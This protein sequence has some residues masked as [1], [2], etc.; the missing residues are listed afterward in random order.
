VGCGLGGYKKEGGGV[1][2]APIYNLMCCKSLILLGLL[3][4]VC[5]NGGLFVHIIMYMQAMVPNAVRGGCPGG[6]GR[7]A[8]LAYVPQFATIYT[9]R[10]DWPGP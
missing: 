8:G 4:W 1:R 7:A 9:W 10:R 3:F 2:L 6:G 5:Q